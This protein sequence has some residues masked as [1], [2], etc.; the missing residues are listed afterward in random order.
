MIRLKLWKVSLSF[1]HNIFVINDNL[2]NCEHQNVSIGQGGDMKSR[3][4]KFS[5]NTSNFQTHKNT[6]FQKISFN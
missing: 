4:L 1:T 2:M 6:I 3:D 5:R